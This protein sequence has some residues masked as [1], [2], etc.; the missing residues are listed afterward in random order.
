MNDAD[1]PDGP[2]VEDFRDYL[3]VLARMQ[4]GPAARN[5][6]EASDMVQQTLLEACRK[7][8][9][10]R[11]HCAAEMAGWLRQLL[12]FN[13]ADAARAAGRVKRDVAR[14][15]SLEAALDQSS[16]RLGAWLAADQSSPSERA[17]CHELAARLAGVLTQVPEAQRQALLL[18]YC[19]DCSVEE[20]SRRLD[21]T[22]AAVAGL[23]KRGLR[24]LR[25][26]LEDGR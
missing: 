2:V 6:L 1:R 7:R 19:Q 17:E 12:A 13:L 18:R 16:A 15:R 14:E 5:K 22:P 24:Q 4:L 23:L 26:L 10:F 3:L 8:D 20:I 21:R 25:T 11:G 9:Q